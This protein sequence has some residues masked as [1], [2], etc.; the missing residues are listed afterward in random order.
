MSL[1][2]L[3][4]QVLA[5]QAPAIKKDMQKQIGDAQSDAIKKRQEI[6]AT[7]D[8]IKKQLP[9][10][11]KEW[12]GKDLDKLLEAIGYIHVNDLFGKDMYGKPFNLEMVIIGLNDRRVIEMDNYF[13]ESIIGLYESLLKAIDEDNDDYRKIYEDNFEPRFR[14]FIGYVQRFHKIAF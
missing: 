6:L 7:V 10:E 4:K 13:A 14:G 9:E 3:R 1:E 5:A 11:S 8:R 12:F 2:A